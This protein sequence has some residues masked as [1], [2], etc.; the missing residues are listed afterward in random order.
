MKMRRRRIGGSGYV[1]EI[2]PFVLLLTLSSSLPPSLPHRKA[3]IVED[4]LLIDLG[5]RRHLFHV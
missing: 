1:N 4:L 5:A 2:L 3:D